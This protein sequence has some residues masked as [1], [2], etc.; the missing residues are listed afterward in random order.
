MLQEMPARSHPESSLP[1]RDLASI[2]CSVMHAPSAEPCALPGRGPSASRRRKSLAPYPPLRSARLAGAPGP[3]HCSLCAG[4]ALSPGH[5]RRLVVRHQDARG[6]SRR[7]PAV[8][9]AP[10]RPHDRARALSAPT[11]A[12][13]AT[14]R[15]YAAA[16]RK[17]VWRCGRRGAPLAR[18]GP[19]R[20][21]AHR[22]AARGWALRRAAPAVDVYPRRVAGRRGRR[23]HE[24]AAHGVRPP[25]GHGRL[26]RAEARR[27]AARARRGSARR[28]RVP[29]V[30]AREPPVPRRGRRLA[31]HAGRPGWRG[32][33]WPRHRWLRG[34]ATRGRAGAAAGAARKRRRVR[35]GQG[36]AEEGRRAPWTRGGVAAGQL[37]DVPR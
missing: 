20:G 21:S 15:R 29:L 28:A 23:A 36:Q 35:R 22:A 12:C 10:P 14:L 31:H 7:L 27:R 18:N 17:A 4:P 30:A 5:S 32:G 13:A 37:G 8:H 34:A 11:A 33:R 24:C 2:T 19:G 25:A 6:R 26:H 1:T 9:S 16:A 3:A